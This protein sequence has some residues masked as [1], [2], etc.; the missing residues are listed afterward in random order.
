MLLIVLYEFSTNIAIYPFNFII[1]I[2]FLYHCITIVNNTPINAIHAVSTAS[3]ISFSFGFRIKEYPDMFAVL[4]FLPALDPFPRKLVYL[5]RFCD[6][7][8]LYWCHSLEA[9]VHDGFI[10]R[11]T[12]RINSFLHLLKCYTQAVI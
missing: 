11:Q 3:N 10:I 4:L 6:G 2:A 1:N 12:V 7:K 8:V 5:S 9:S